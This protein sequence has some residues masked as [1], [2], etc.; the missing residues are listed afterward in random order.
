MANRTHGL[1][2][3]LAE[4]SQHLAVLDAPPAAAQQCMLSSGFH[5]H[6]FGIHLLTGICAHAFKR[7]GKAQ[8]ETFVCYNK[9]RKGTNNVPP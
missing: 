3:L 8:M 1:S 5:H 2:L 7:G 4:E 9:T 6:L